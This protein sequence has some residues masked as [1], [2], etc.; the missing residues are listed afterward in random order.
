MI[1]CWGYG[2]KTHRSAHSTSPSGLCFFIQR[3]WLHTSAVV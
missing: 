2:K 3:I 1:L